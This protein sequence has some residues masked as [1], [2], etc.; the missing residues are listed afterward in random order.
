MRSIVSVNPFRC[1]VWELHDRLEEHISEESCKAEIQ[2]F[3][4]H[5]QLVPALGRRLS[6]DAS[7]DV[8]LIYGARR[9]FV[10]RHI[11]H[12]LLV[13]LC[14]MTDLQ[15]VVAMDTENRQRKD[16]S[17]YERGLSY[18]RWLRAGYFDSQEAMARTLKVSASQVS[19]LLRLA[20]LPSVVVSAFAS[21]VD[22]CEG[23]GLELAE[24]LEDPDRRRAMIQRA[25]SIAASSPRPP[26]RD[27]YRRLMTSAT[28]GPHPKTLHD[29]VVK[30]NEGDALF[31]VRYQSNS[32]ALILP[33]N[34]VSAQALQRI[35]TAVAAILQVPQPVEHHAKPS[36]PGV[37]QPAPRMQIAQ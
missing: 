29:S 37:V 23:W 5:G 3:L 26:A 13:E 2:S 14:E 21:A 36:A 17:P 4:E 35:Q 12:S 8:E 32:I 31:R 20:R 16:I 15:A 19:R 22:I 7:Y 9:L 11:N 25:R 33:I 6:G 27:V 1:R 28:R 30:S 34:N 18:A 24:A 10:A